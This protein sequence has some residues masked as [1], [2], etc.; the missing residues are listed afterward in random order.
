MEEFKMAKKNQKQNR[1]QINFRLT[2]DEWE[3]LN[4]QL[5]KHNI[6]M[7]ISAYAKQQTL[8]GEI[9]CLGLSKDDAKKITTSL[10]YI[11]NNFNQIAK[12]VNKT[13]HF[14]MY[15][16][17][18]MLDEVEELKKLLL[19]LLELKE[20]K[21]IKKLSPEQ[22]QLKK[23]YARLERNG[24]PHNIGRDVIFGVIVAISK[25]TTKAEK[26]KLIAEVIAEK[27]ITTDLAKKIWQI[28]CYTM[29]EE[30]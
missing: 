10:A 21:K 22:K 9:N 4:Y 3:W 14:E 15:L 11:S 27:N 30:S 29:V 13:G 24:I 26:N 25:A 2:D 16:H 18:N 23:F 7:S 1:R 28:Y 19:N 12:Q 6:Q 5:Q 8:Y 20:Q 17:A